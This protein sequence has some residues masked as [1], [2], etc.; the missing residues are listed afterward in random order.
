MGTLNHDYPTIKYEYFFH[1]LG[2]RVEMCKLVSHALVSLFFVD[3]AG[4]H[5]K[6]VCVR[7]CVRTEDTPCYVCHKNFYV[8]SLEY[9]V[10]IIVLFPFV[11]I[12][13]DENPSKC[14]FFSVHRFGVLL[15]L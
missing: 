15:K 4:V 13:T 14:M 6:F 11:V 2:E 9:H 10:D 3:I 5:A 1:Q 12:I 8:S 7:N